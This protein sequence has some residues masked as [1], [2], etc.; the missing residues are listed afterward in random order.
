[1]SRMT[2]RNSREKLLPPEYIHAL[3]EVG[4]LR[5]P[6]AVD[7]PLGRQQSASIRTGTI[8]V[9][10]RLRIAWRSNSSSRPLGIVR[11][12]EFE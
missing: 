6:D 4:I 12:V 1:V 8:P 5:A 9:M 2:E 7:G 10:K 11:H 3:A